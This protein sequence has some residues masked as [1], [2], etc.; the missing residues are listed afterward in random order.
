MCG[1]GAWDRR[2]GEVIGVVRWSMKAPKA[3]A[4]IF[5]V[6]LEMNSGGILVF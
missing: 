5:Q 2:E 4:A 1:G 3:W 6:E